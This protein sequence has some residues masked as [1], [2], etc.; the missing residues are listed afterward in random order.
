MA[1][2]SEKYMLEVSDMTGKTSKVLLPTFE[3]KK[4]RKFYSKIVWG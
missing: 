3:H 4:L 1:L 2:L